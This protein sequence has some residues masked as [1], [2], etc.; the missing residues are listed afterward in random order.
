MLLLLKRIRRREKDAQF[1][2]KSSSPHPL[3]ESLSV[4]LPPSGTRYRDI[5]TR[6]DNEPAGES[7]IL[8]D[9]YSNVV[10]FRQRLD[11][12]TAT[13]FVVGNIFPD[14]IVTVP[15]SRLSS[16]DREILS[17][18]CFESV[19]TVALREKAAAEEASK[20]AA[21]RLRQQAAE[22][23]P[24]RIRGRTGFPASPLSSNIRS[25]VKT[26]DVSPIY[27][28]DAQE[29]RVQGVVIVEMT[30]GKDGTVQDASILRSIPLLDAAALDC[31]RQWEYRPT[32]LYGVPVAL[33]M[34]VTVQFTLS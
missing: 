27:P 34:L 4:L 12:I 8:F 22:L 14:D 7:N 26:K 6:I 18:A 29:A 10:T 28:S 30:I 13:R 19:K 20:L 33:I 5:Q 25:P 31:V 32:L 16:A 21:A 2:L 11:S 23:G 24:I 1:R 3:L 17:N 15:F 9:T